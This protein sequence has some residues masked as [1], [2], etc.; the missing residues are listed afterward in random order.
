MNELEKE[1]EKIKK[2]CKKQT[3]NSLNEYLIEVL[4]EKIDFY[5][6]GVDFLKYDYDLFTNDDI[7]NFLEE[8]QYEIE[9]AICD[10]N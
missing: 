4:K 7:Y 5:E 1:L 3:K 2:E 10:F 6:K 9:K 8:K